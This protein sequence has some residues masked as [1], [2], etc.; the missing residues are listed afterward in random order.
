MNV[1]THTDSTSVDAVVIGGG[2]AGMAAALQ[3]GRMRRRVLVVDAGE[4][5][6]APAAH[7]HG[8][9]G[10]DG[11]PPSELAA[12]ARREVAAYGVEVVDGRVTS[13]SGSVTAG[14]TVELTSG[15]RRM[16]R[17]VVLATGITDELPDIAGVREEWG[18]GVIHCPYCHGW[19]VRDRRLVVIDTAGIGGHQAMLFRQLSAS[20]TLVVHAGAGP[21]AARRDQLAALEV[22]VIDTAVDAVITA[23]DA[24]NDS[25]VGGVV[26][27][28]LAGGRVLDADAVVVGPRFRPNVAMVDALDVA[29]EPHPMG[30]GEFVPTSPMGATNVPGVYAAG[31]LTDP[32]NQVLQA[33][34]RGAMV[35][36]F[37]NM[38]LVEEDAAA[39]LR[40]RVDAQ[41]WDAR[42][43][44]AEHRMWSGA[45]NGSLA[46]ELEHVA[47]GRI[48]DIGCGEGADA[49]WLAQRGW[50][51]TAVD[52]SSLAIERA[53][54]AGDDAG[55]SIDWQCADVLTTPPAPGRYDVVTIQYPA[56][57]REAGEVAIRRLLDAVRPGGAFLVVGHVLDEEHARRHGHDMAQFVALDE[58]R[59][60][61]GDEFMVEVD[62]VRARPNPPPGAHHADDAVLRARRN[63]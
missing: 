57:L 36:A 42:Y 24:A 11:L 55:V 3:L 33:A 9:L 47:P 48:L 28:R 17:R 4:P 13:V 21:D 37:V 49:I 26:G 6:N 30:V 25:T 23:G 18:R 34:A 52:I 43:G 35:G 8:Y 62:E 63:R 59:A 50:E 39:A 40:S 60:A 7:M 44:D 27:V 10:H 56:L 58:L 22:D 2:G 32:S 5:R 16:A 51:V 20:V 46:V 1:S 14:F 41:R 15:D 31:N 54:R 12:I 38:D 61:L 45:V 29:T 19:E 53:R